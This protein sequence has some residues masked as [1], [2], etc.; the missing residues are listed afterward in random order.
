VA[1]D[2]RAAGTPDGWPGLLPGSVRAADVAGQRVVVAVAG[3]RRPDMTVGCRTSAAAEARPDHCASF[4]A[5]P[6]SSRRTNIRQSPEVADL[7]QQPVQLTPPPASARPEQQNAPS[8]AVRIEPA[9]KTRGI[10][11]VQGWA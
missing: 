8:P 7:G 11:A 3:V 5:W 10:L 6:V 1:D 9:A 2:G 4:P